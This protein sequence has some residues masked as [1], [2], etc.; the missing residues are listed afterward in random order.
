MEAGNSASQDRNVQTVRPPKIELKKSKG[1]IIIK[2]TK[3][4]ENTK[5]D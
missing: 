1:E 5:V 4:K 2:I 3:E